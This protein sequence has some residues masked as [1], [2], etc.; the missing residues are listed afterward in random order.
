MRT[1]F[2]GRC[3][4]WLPGCS[5]LQ[6]A[7]TTGCTQPRR[8]PSCRCLP[9][10]LSFW[11]AFIGTAPLI[12]RCPKHRTSVSTCYPSPRLRY[13][14]A[15][16]P[17]HSSVTGLTTCPDSSDPAVSPSSRAVLP[18]WKCRPNRPPQAGTIRSSSAALHGLNRTRISLRWCIT[19]G[20]IKAWRSWSDPIRRHDVP[21][22]TSGPDGV[23]RIARHES[24]ARRF[25]VQDDPRAAAVNDLQM[26]HGKRS[27]P[28]VRQLDVNLIT[29]P[30][31]FQHTEMRVAMP[32]YD[33]VP[34]L[35]RQDARRVMHWTE[36]QVAPTGPLQHQQ[37]RDS[38]AERQL[39]DGAGVRPPPDIVRGAILELDVSRTRGCASMPRA[40]PKTGMMVARTI[41]FVPTEAWVRTFSSGFQPLLELSKDR[42]SHGTMAV[43]ATHVCAPP[44]ADARMSRHGKQR[45]CVLLPDGSNMNGYCPPAGI[46]RNSQCAKASGIPLY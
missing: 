34:P 18:T 25:T 6:L 8:P 36:C 21:Q 44:N 14:R 12:G 23:E 42:V 24:Q 4:I 35:T 37:H 22:R 40:S 15:S 26:R 43:S 29:Q 27:A 39:R 45:S 46:Y 32:L 16:R 17:R 11:S 33:A 2:E 28:A 38:A 41:P 10:R 19:R 13:P 7:W 20:A 31:I 9:S 1:H 5:S 3:A 30:E